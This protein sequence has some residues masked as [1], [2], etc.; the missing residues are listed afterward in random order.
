MIFRQ[1]AH[2]VE[3]KYLIPSHTRDR[4]RRVMKFSGLKEIICIGL[5][6]V[7]FAGDSRAAQEEK[8]LLDLRRVADK[9]PPE[10]EKF[11]GVPSKLIDDIFRS[12]RGYTYPAIRAIY[13]NGAIEVTY[14]E[15]GARYFKIWIQKLGGKYQDYSYPKDMGPLL[16][17]LGLDRNIPADFSN[18]TL[19]RW[20]DLPDLYE[21]NVFTTGEKQ[22]WY[23]HV[24]TSRIYE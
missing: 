11:L 22:I 4:R 1:P 17:D 14:L 20:R 7:I 23:V 12:T 13:M 9:P 2:S 24:L 19:T 5:L 8:V 15:G 6:S 18:Q 16:A 21:I 10:I 3:M